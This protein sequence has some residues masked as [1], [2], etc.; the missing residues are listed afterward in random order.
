MYIVFLLPEYFSWHY[1]KAL[2][3]SLNIVTNFIWFAYHFFS[4]PV[5]IRTF[6]HPWHSQAGEIQ[7]AETSFTRI[8]MQIIGPVIRA[9]VLIFGLLICGA[10]AAV[11]LIGFIVWLLLPLIVVGLLY[12]AVRQLLP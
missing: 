4:I 6:A 7:S 1:T 11:G 5:L 9:V 8:F 10:I 12:E 2:K 3:F